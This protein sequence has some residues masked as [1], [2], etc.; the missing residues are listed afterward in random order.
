MSSRRQRSIPLGGRYRQVSLYVLYV[1]FWMN[2]SHSRFLVRSLWFWFQSAIIYE[3]QPH[4]NVQWKSAVYIISHFSRNICI[5]D[6]AKFHNL[7]LG[8]H[9]YDSTHFL[10]FLSALIFMKMVWCLSTFDHFLCAKYVKKRTI[11]LFN[12]LSCDMF[13][14]TRIFS[15]VRRYVYTLCLNTRWYKFI[16]LRIKDITNRVL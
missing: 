2:S 9:L 8:Q 6:V 3:E 1:S 4:N 12:Y 10:W 15:Y 7:H 16:H 11:R 13:K 5:S 14:I